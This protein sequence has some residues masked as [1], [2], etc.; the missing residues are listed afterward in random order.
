MLSA[1]QI[2]ASS[3]N[4]ISLS[5]E[6]FN[7]SRSATTGFIQPLSGNFFKYAWTNIQDVEIL[8]GTVL[9]LTNDCSCPIFQSKNVC[10]DGGS[11][12]TK[13]FQY[14]ENNDYSLESL[15]NDTSGGDILKS[16][17][18]G[19]NQYAITTNLTNYETSSLKCN[20]IEFN[21]EVLNIPTSSFNNK[22]S[23][24]KILPIHSDLGFAVSDFR[25]ELILKNNTRTLV[26]FPSSRFIDHINLN[27]KFKN[28]FYGNSICNSDLIV[29]EKDKRKETYWLSGNSLEDSV[30]MQ[31][32]QFNKNEF[33][34]SRVNTLNHYFDYK[35]EYDRFGPDRNKDYLSTFDDSLFLSLSSWNTNLQSQ[36]NHTFQNVGFINEDYN[37]H[38]L[39][40]NAKRFAYITNDILNSLVTNN[41]SINF[42]YKF[43]DLESSFGQIFGNYY[44][45]GFGLIFNNG[46]D[47]NH[48][49]ILGKNG[50]LYSL[51]RDGIL[52]FLKDLKKT[53]KYTNFELKYIAN[54]LD[55]SRWIYDDYNR[56]ILKYETDDI[57]S[58][59]IELDKDVE[60]SSNKKLY[61]DKSNNLWFM[62]TKD[63]KFYCYSE[64]GWLL[65]T[66]TYSGNYNNFYF[67][68]ASEQP[69]PCLNTFVEFDSQKNRYEFI[70]LNLYKNGKILRHFGKVIS[71]FLIDEYNNLVI[72]FDNQILKLKSDGSVIYKKELVHS[73]SEES[74]IKINILK[75]KFGNQNYIIAFNDNKIL[76][77]VSEEGV[78]LDRI[79]LYEVLKTSNNCED[80]DLNT[81]GDFTGHYVQKVSNWNSSDLSFANKANPYILIKLKF[82]TNCDTY[83]LWYDNIAL[84][85]FIDNRFHNYHFDV[86][87]EKGLIK[88]YINSDLKK[89]IY[90]GPYNLD[91]YKKYSENLSPFIVG[92]NSGKI[93]SLNQE[94]NNNDSYLTGEIQNF[95]WYDRSL[96]YFE[97]RSLFLNDKFYWQ[98]LVMDSNITNA[99][100]RNN[101]SRV[102]K[103]EYFY[104]TSFPGAYSNYFNVNVLNGDNIS[105]TNKKIIETE[106]LKIINQTKP[107]HTFLN[108]VVWE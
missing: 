38:S 34:D 51:N 26:A 5:G 45:N 52:T 87:F 3:V 18:N 93:G 79:N 99:L 58:S 90:V 22:K 36:S 81:N 53:T 95:R 98:D 29:V 72:V 4:W 1:R 77:K 13:Y 68:L 74:N 65:T 107:E 66:V 59:I 8:D 82:N 40:L 69:T 2:S 49:T 75:D 39:E 27:E 63:K 57:V 42:D 30:W 67:D 16:Y 78:V 103:V 102:E 12:T 76:L 60:L 83:Q 14:T 88:F 96:N 7:D 101:Q 15:A 105:E 21:S 91:V 25:K 28:G 73:I 85:H 54:D 17:I 80:L 62:S 41:F 19:G 100:E 32:V 11:F 44:K 89:E 86:D 46:M 9:F 6:Y 10:C 108:E 97:I 71:D 92:G 84:A 31:R 35:I 94:W 106:L 24:N 33:S 61:I 56:I 64:K 43:I 20:Y 37:N 55:G 50:I 104:K 23:I 47:N 70:G 48:I